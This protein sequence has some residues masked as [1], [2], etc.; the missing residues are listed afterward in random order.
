MKTRY[1]YIHFV[2]IA[3]KR[4]TQVWECRNNR[5]DAVLGVVKWYSGW[6]QYVIWPKRECFFNQ[7]CLADVEHF[8]N[9]LNQVHKTKTRRGGKY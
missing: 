1:R 5:T 2:E 8:L 9:Q 4:K 6:R 7:S 3:Q